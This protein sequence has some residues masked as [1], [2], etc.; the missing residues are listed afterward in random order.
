MIEYIKLWRYSGM[1]LSATGIIHIIVAITQEWNIYKELFFDGLINSISNNTQ[2][3]LSFWFFI[4]G[5]ILIMFGQ[6]LHYYI[7]KEQL[8]AP[9]FLGYALLIFSILGCFIV[10]ISGFW[11]FI[12]Q[13]LIIIFAKR[14]HNKLA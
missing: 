5:V 10:P 7:N 13:A 11:L 12:P 6:S 1:L 9:L 8:P 4:I 3:A 14:K 2:K